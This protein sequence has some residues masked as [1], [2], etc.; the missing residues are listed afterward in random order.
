MDLELAVPAVGQAAAAIFSDTADTNGR[1]LRMAVQ[2]VRLPTL[3]RPLTFAVT[4][5]AAALAQETRRFNLLLG[6]ALSGLGIG[7][8]IAVVLQTHVGLRPLRRVVADIESV[9]TGAVE[10]LTATGTHE[11]DTLVQEINTLVTHNRRILERARTSAA[12]LAHALKTPLAILK[13]DVA[14]EQAQSSQEQVAAMERIVARYLTRA[15]TAGPGR[16]VKTAIAPLVTAIVKSMDR[17]H[18]T[19]ALHVSVAIDPS[20]SV[21]MDTEDFAEIA[22]NLLENAYKWARSTLTIRALPHDDVIRFEVEDDGPGLDAAQAEH[23]AGRGQRF[24]THVP[25]TGLGLAIVADVVEIYGGKLELSRAA[26][27]GLRAEVKLPVQRRVV[28]D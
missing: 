9:R 10:H 17:V 20:L 2:T 26:M 23:A 12:D 16:E 11:L 27:G 6:L 19:K 3:E 1:A 15:A 25:G 5:D 13:S 22:G 7:L 14:N 28:R 24:D 18:A 21:S 4:A 8:L